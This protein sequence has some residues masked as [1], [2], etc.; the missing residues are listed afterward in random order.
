MVETGSLINVYNCSN[1]PLFGDC[2]NVV[3]RTKLVAKHQ[4]NT[5][6]QFWCGDNPDLIEHNK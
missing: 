1:C 6:S 2:L 3:E 5:W 4:N